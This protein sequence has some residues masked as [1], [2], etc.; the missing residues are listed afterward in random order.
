MIS[1]AHDKV[2]RK[3][4]RTMFERQGVR[5]LFVG[6]SVYILELI[7]IIVAQKVG[8]TPTQA[9]ALSFTLGLI[10]S[11]FL[12]KILSFGDKRMHHKI[13][14]PQAIAVGL[15][16]VWNFS[17]TIGVTR[18]LTDALPPTLTR[19]IALGIT[20]IWNFYLYKTHIFTPSER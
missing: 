20:T 19:T 11:F 16:V 5:Y 18:L 4:A 15:L 7:I 6:G 2:W 14:I 9:V 1:E 3:R 17:F 12:Q 10:I 8:A 13:L